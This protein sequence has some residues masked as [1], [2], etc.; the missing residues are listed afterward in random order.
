MGRKV[1]SLPFNS[2]SKHISEASRVIA[3]GNLEK[4]HLKKQ[5][6]SSF[7]FRVVQGWWIRGEKNP[8]LTELWKY[9]ATFLLHMTLLNHDIF[10]QES[11]FFIKITG[12][13][14]KAGLS[15]FRRDLL[16]TVGF[17]GLSFC[18][19][20]EGSFTSSISFVRHNSFL[21]TLILCRIKNQSASVKSNTV[22]EFIITVN[23]VQSKMVI[24]I[25]LN[26]CCSAFK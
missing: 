6:L 9:L 18:Y 14:G 25:S 22:P 16:I 11:R 10:P 3:S 21:S 8:L 15:R 12:T 20:Q 7:F 23:L 4:R 17:G 5:L 24:E 19:F 2:F 13:K 1:G 26:N